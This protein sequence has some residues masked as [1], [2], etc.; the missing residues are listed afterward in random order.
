MCVVHP[1]YYLVSCSL[2]LQT[3]VTNPDPACHFDADP[4]PNPSFLAQNLEKV[5]K[6]AHIPH[7]L[8]CYLQIDEDP[9]PDPAYYFDADPYPDYHFYADPCGSGTGSTRLPRRQKKVHKKKQR[10]GR[11]F[12]LDGRGFSWSLEALRGQSL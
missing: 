1:G 10:A 3:G 6:Q 4:D 8:A 2:F 11:T 5:L 7:I 9:D 12:S